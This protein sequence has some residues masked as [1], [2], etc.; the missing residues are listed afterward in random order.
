[1]F[2]FHSWYMLADIS[3]ITSMLQCHVGI[4]TPVLKIRFENNYALCFFVVQKSR[5]GS[6][7]KFLLIIKQVNLAT[8]AIPSTI[9]Q[10]YTIWVLTS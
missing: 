3:Y 1:M 5:R 6:K 8:K 10:K 2:S 9:Q 4:T 7:N